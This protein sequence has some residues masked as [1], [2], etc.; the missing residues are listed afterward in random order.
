MTFT[1]TPEIKELT[2][3]LLAAVK[4]KIT[5]PF[6]VWIR[7]TEIENYCGINVNMTGKYQGEWWIVKRPELE[8]KEAIMMCKSLHDY[9]ITAMKRYNVAQDRDQKNVAEAEAINHLN[10][11]ALCLANAKK[12]GL[13]IETTV[14]ELKMN[15]REW[16][17]TAGYPRKK[18]TGLEELMTKYQRVLSGSN[19]LLTPKEIVVGPANPG[20]VQ[21]GIDMLNQARELQITAK[22][23][24]FDA[25]Q[26][27]Y[28]MKKIAQDVFPSATPAPTPSM[29]PVTLAK[30]A[31]TTAQQSCSQHQWVLFSYT[32]YLC[33]SCKFTASYRTSTPQECRPCKS[34]I[35]CSSCASNYHRRQSCQLFSC[36][37]PRSCQICQQ[38]I[39]PSKEY[40]LCNSCKNGAC[41]TCFS[42]KA[43]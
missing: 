16:Q 14:E 32:M 9:M 6:D 3:K 40:Y 28:C 18:Q 17:A 43:I 22:E 21:K 31:T 5:Q 25:S 35:I 41:T 13:A 23:Q 33:S 34:G 29:V 38:Q 15:A 7:F 11:L 20:L 12:A 27:Q 19:E 30:T 2:D 37:Q 4:R 26:Y 24:G 1:P 8:L 10:S 39:S 36:E 42:K